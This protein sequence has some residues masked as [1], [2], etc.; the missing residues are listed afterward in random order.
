MTESRKP[1]QGPP[2]APL[3][4]L[5]LLMEWG[6]A[7]VARRA[8]IGQTVVCR[9]ETGEHGLEFA[10]TK[11]KAARGYGLTVSQFDRLCAGDLT[12][13]RARVLARKACKSEQFA[14]G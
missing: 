2:R 3:V 9:I 7:D 12:V 8:G 6:Q 5:R 14:T 4:A 10:A 13:D 11:E 1:R